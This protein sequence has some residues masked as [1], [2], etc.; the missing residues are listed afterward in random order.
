[1]KDMDTEEQLPPNLAAQ[2]WGIE[3]TF[4]DIWGKPHKT[5]PEAQR[6]ILK[7]LGV[8]D[9]DEALDE[10]LWAE[11]SQPL[12]LT[13]VLGPKG[14]IVLTLPESRA[15]ERVELAFI[16]EDSRHAHLSFELASLPVAEEMVLRSQNFVR[17]RLALP[18]DAPL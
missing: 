9:V 6:A 12:P 7:S 17:K 5:S 13:I 18:E 10:K 1:M 16:W 11:W 15:R 8:S 2:A 3:E 14:E 4:Y